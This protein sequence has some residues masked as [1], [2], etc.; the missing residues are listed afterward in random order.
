MPA[1]VSGL[2]GVEKGVHRLSSGQPGTLDPTPDQ[3]VSR[4]SDATVGADPCGAVRGGCCHA[5]I[6]PAMGRNIA[7]CRQFEPGLVLVGSQKRLCHI[8]AVFLQMRG[9]PVRGGLNDKT[10]TISIGC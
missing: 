1:T 6:A 7:R 4:Q 5:R 8:G 2:A 9:A 10:R 3:P